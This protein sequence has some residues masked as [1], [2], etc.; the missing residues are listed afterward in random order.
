MKRAYHFIKDKNPKRKTIGKQTFDEICKWAKYTPPEP[1]PVGCTPAD[2]RVLR[3]ANLDLAIRVDK[4][5]NM[6]RNLLTIIA[7]S[8]DTT[9]GRT[10]AEA[11]LK[12]GGID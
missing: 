6:I 12:E 3:H 4:L 10:E 8:E 9:K 5:E 11:L 2:A 1:W 7:N